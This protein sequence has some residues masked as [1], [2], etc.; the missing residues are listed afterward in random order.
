MWIRCSNCLG[1]DI[2]GIKSK[3]FYCKNCCTKTS[4]I[5]NTWKIFEAE[6]DGSLILLNDFFMVYKKH[7]SWDYI[8]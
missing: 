4:W 3:L 8:V 6:S 1:K 5:G 2:E 7:F